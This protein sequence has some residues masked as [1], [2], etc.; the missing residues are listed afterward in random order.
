MVSARRHRASVAGGRD[1]HIA[2]RVLLPPQPHELEQSY[3][4]DPAGIATLSSGEKARR[5]SRAS[6]CPFGME[7]LHKHLKSRN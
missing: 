2:V 7:Q 5:A 1:A 6:R 3:A 4:I